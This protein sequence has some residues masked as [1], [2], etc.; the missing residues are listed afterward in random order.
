MT[1]PLPVPRS[2]EPAWERFVA[3]PRRPRNA[4][5]RVGHADRDVLADLL[6]DAYAYG[7]LDTIE[8]NERLDKAMQVRTVGEIMP[9]VGDLMTVPAAAS[10]GGGYGRSTAARV[11]FLIAGTAVGL[12][13]LIWLFASLSAGALLYFWPMWVAVGMVVPVVIGVALGRSDD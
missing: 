12:N 2:S 8:Y 13:V 10:R 11:L 6:A 3:D 1:A 4:E 9:L 7:R 5:I